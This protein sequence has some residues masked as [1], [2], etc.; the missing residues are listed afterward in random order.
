MNDYQKVYEHFASVYTEEVDC[1][2]DGNEQLEVVHCRFHSDFK[3]ERLREN[4]VSGDLYY[5]ELSQQYIDENAE[6]LYPVI[7][8]EG[9][10][11][12]SSAIVMLH[13]LNERSWRK[14]LPWAEYLARKTRRPVILFPIAYHMNR[15]PK[16]WSDPRQMSEVSAARRSK[17]ELKNSSFLNA[18]ISTRLQYHP[19]QFIYSGLQSFFDL[20]KLVRSVKSG[21][22]E[23]FHEG[24]LPDLFAYSIGAFLAEILF[25]NNPDRL[26]DRSKLFLFCGGCT[27]DHM[28][29]E[30]KFIMDNKAFES[31]ELLLQRRR[32]KRIR[33]NL[34][35]FGIPE[36]DQAWNGLFMMMHGKNRRSK[37]E[38]IFTRF[39][40]Q[41][42]AVGL[43]KDNVI[44]REGIIETLK[45]PQGKLPAHVEIIDFPFDYSHENPFPV[46]ADKS[47]HLVD[48]AFHAV[49]DKAAKFFVETYIV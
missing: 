45:G 35:R 47:Q 2:I 8:P 27:F 46:L 4:F 28:K 36:V 42:F 9:K 10:R 13:G 37:R 24:T 15:S 26:F 16:I 3:T 17:L 31:L 23:L 19:E 1:I 11:K 38:K 43:E 30:S 21:Q 41:I 20:T 48:R 32:L 18:A 5:H 49:F 25:L 12:Y 34:I 40:D 7:L 14:Y 6:F 22:H 33:K 29:G 44:V 39:G